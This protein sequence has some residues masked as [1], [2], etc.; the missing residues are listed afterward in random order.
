M[1]AGEAGYTVLYSDGSPDGNYGEDG[2]IRLVLQGE[3]TE[4]THIHVVASDLRMPAGKLRF[5]NDAFNERHRH[6]Y[7]D[8][9]PA[10]TPPAADT[11]ACPFCAETIKAAAIVCRFC[12]RDLLR[13]PAPFSPAAA[14]A[15]LSPSGLTPERT[16]AIRKLT[17]PIPSGPSPKQQSTGSGGVAAVV[18]VLIVLFGL[19]TTYNAMKNDPSGRAELRQMGIEVD[20]PPDENLAAQEAARQQTDEAMRQIEAATAAAAA[21][22]AAQDSDPEFDPQ[23]VRFI[24]GNYGQQVLSGYVVNTTDRTLRYLRADAEYLD[25]S[26]N[27]IATGMDNT[28]DDLPPG[29]KWRFEANI[30]EVDGIK[31]GRIIRVIGNYK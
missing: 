9:E 24:T 3:V 5:L 25:K 15:A 6:V 13:A 19:G 22:A 16:E 31:T 1:A 14:P 30:P 28:G 7:G 26:G 17:E 4:S 2:L 12:N 11:K 18:L 21:A 10:S 29:G 20:T 23:D 27:V 8:P